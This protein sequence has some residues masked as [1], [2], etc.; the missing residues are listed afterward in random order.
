MEFELNYYQ[1][2]DL[3]RTPE[4]NDRTFKKKNAKEKY[5][6]EHK[7]LMNIGLDNVI[8]DELHLFLRYLFF[9]Y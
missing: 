7:P 1:S 5:C 6:C 3:K 2:A 4:G 8:L 9:F